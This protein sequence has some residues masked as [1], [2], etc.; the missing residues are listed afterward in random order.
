MTSKSVDI[1]ILCFSLIVFNCFVL[2]C[3]NTI[4]ATP[5]IRS[6]TRGEFLKHFTRVKWQPELCHQFHLHVSR[7]LLPLDQIHPAGIACRCDWVIMDDM[8][9][10]NH[11][12]IFMKHD[13]LPR[14]VFIP[15]ASLGY[16]SSFVDLLPSRIVLLSGID[17]RTFP[18]NLDSRFPTTEETQHG[19]MQTFYKIVNSSSV[20]HWFIENLSVKHPKVSPLPVGVLY[21]PIQKHFLSPN[22]LY[23]NLMNAAPNNTS[24][25]KRPVLLLS[26]DRYREGKGQWSARRKSAEA[27]RKVSFCMTGD[28]Y[29]DSRFHYY[30]GRAKRSIENLPHGIFVHALVHSKFT[31][32]VHGGGLD[33]CPKLF[34]AI[35]LGSIPII[36]E[37][38]ISS[39]FTP[40]HLPVA[41]VPNIL[42]FLSESRK[43]ESLTLLER[44]S[45]DLGPYYDMKGKH[46]Q[47]T[48]YHLTQ[49]YW[50]SVVNSTF[51]HDTIT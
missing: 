48:L 27:C 49:D 2:C 31:I 40:P 17:D 21:K 8:N 11:H 3:D 20:I 42:E 51:M 12:R 39:T 41:V 1:M 32:M 46:R 29:A 30:S 4:P 10:T 34:E 43:K 50:W 16:F 45:R 19:Y 23:H 6:A 37:S 47:E 26:M 35:I 9:N 13:E 14:F 28:A 24:W 36:E 15:I 7:F 22:D 44:W 18:I 25:E 33:P 5:V 38:T